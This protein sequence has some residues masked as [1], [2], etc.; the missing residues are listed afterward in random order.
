MRTVK[1]QSIEYMLPILQVKC[2]IIILNIQG[3]NNT[4]MDILRDFLRFLN[5]FVNEHSFNTDDLLQVIR[6]NLDLIA[7]VLRPVIQF[8][9][10]TITSS[11]ANPCVFERL[12]FSIDAIHQMIALM[13]DIN[14]S[15][16]GRVFSEFERFQSRQREALILLTE[17]LTNMLSNL[18]NRYASYIENRPFDQMFLNRIRAYSS[19]KSCPVSWRPLVEGVIGTLRGPD[20]LR[21]IICRDCR[22]EHV[23]HKV[24]GIIQLARNMCRQVPNIILALEEIITSLEHLQEQSHNFDLFMTLMVMRRILQHIPHN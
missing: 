21:A 10:D 19:S 13:N 3:H 2:D 12:N 20:C 6:G 15:V 8:I 7:I 17:N 16:I 24:N 9:I 1:H 23:V 18:G 5:S 4:V 14:H 22:H 11:S